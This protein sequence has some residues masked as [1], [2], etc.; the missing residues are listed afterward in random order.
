M[1]IGTVYQELEGFGASGPWHEGWLT[2]HPKKNELY[3]ILFGQLGLD[4]Y[5]LRN[6]YHIYDDWSSGINTNAEIIR[7]A[8]AS[9]R[10]PIKIMIS[11][12]SPPGYL[13]SN[14]D[15]AGGTL[16]RHSD[17]SYKYD[18]FAQWWADSLDAYERHGIDVDYVN[19]QNEPDWLA[20]YDSCKFTPAETSEWAG[21]NQAFEA[22][23]QELA[24]RMTDM[25]KLLVSDSF[26]CSAL[27]AFIDELI[28]PSHA[29]GYAHHLYSD[30]EYDDPD[31]F[32]IAF[33]GIVVHR[34][35]VG[36]RNGPHRSPSGMGQNR[37]I[38]VFEVHDGLK[39][40][41]VSNLPANENNIIAKASDLRG[42]LVG[43]GERD[44]NLPGAVFCFP[45]A[46]APV[47]QDFLLRPFIELVH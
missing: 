17:G 24:S 8:E 39:D 19:I 14:G 36:F 42:N 5:R 41:I 33:D 31:S 3:N 29:Y 22:V 10:H 1:N 43:D 27:R 15:V 21:Y 20:D 46:D 44:P 45:N 16:A 6:N 40:R 11:S 18:E 9:L 26:G 23:Y 37:M 4:I 35:T 2:G 12:W 13:K 30:G 28:D 34:V 38:K 47:F 32:I 25:P 7:A